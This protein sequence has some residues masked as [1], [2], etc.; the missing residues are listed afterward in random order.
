M[1]TL[2]FANTPNGRKVR[3][4]LEEVGEKYV[5]H[6]V[7]LGKG[8]QFDPQ[9]I[10]I[11]PSSK[12]PAIQDSTP[13]PSAERK[14]LR[15]APDKLSGRL[16]DASAECFSL[17]ESGAILLYLGEKYGRFLGKDPQEKHQITAWLFWQVGG[18]GPMAG[19]YHH[20][21][22]AQADS[23][24]ASSYAQE[25]YRKQ[26]HLLCSVLDRQLEH[27]EFLTATYSVAD[28]ACW[29]WIAWL[30]KMGILNDFPHL[31]TWFERIAQRSA[32]RSLGL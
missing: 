1:I 24:A 18:L 12:I 8:E 14:L 7:D 32:V 30:S 22:A 26:T 16:P 11:S 21:L 27:R 13:G 31:R 3:L 15:A 25:R 29:P 19:Q 10:R 5:L 6:E 9:F 2:Y 28:M 4:F 23:K 17:F 20:F